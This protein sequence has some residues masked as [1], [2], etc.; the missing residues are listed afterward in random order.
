[1]NDFSKIHEAIL[2]AVGDY[3][4]VDLPELVEYL[5]EAADDIE[6]GVTEDEGL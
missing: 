4:T 1:M 2:D 3:E 5:R 6:S